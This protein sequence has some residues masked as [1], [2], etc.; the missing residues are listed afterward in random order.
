MN[1]IYSSHVTVHTSHATRRRGHRWWYRVGSCESVRR[2]RVKTHRNKSVSQFLEIYLLVWSLGISR[3]LFVESC[4]MNIVV[5]TSR[6]VEWLVTPP[7][8]T[9]SQTQLCSG[10]SPVS[11]TASNDPRTY[12]PAINGFIPPNIQNWYQSWEFQTYMIRLTHRR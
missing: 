1:N 5:M 2:L 10:D 12:H 6:S 7:G 8:M 4:K 3:V 9:H 11:S